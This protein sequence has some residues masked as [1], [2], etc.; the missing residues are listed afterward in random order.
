MILAGSAVYV[1][2]I[3]SH[4]SS[5]PDGESDLQFMIDGDIVGSANITPTGSSTYSYN[6]LVYSGQFPTGQHTLTVINGQDGGP[7]SMILLDYI[8]YTNGSDSDFTSSSSSSSSISTTT[9]THTSSGAATDTV[10]ESKN[11]SGG[12]SSAKSSTS[13]LNGST[14]TSSTPSNQTSMAIQASPST[15][16]HTPNVPGST[17]SQGSTTPSA[18]NTSTGTLRSNATSSS[19]SQTRTVVLVAVVLGTVL[20]LAIAAL[21]V[22]WRRRSARQTHTRTARPFQQLSSPFVEEDKEFCSGAQTPHA[23]LHGRWSAL[24]DFARLSARRDEM[25]D[26]SEQWIMHTPPALHEIQSKHPRVSVV[27]SPSSERYPHIASEGSISSE[28][29]V[30]SMEIPGIHN[31]VF[32]IS[33][34]QLAPPPPS[35][36]DRLRSHASMLQLREQLQSNADGSR[37]RNTRDDHTIA[38]RGS[39]ASNTSAITRYVPPVPRAS[40]VQPRADGGVGEYP[41][42]GGNA[43]D[44]KE[45]AIWSRNVPQLEDNRPPSYHSA[46]EKVSE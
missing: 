45:R 11:S 31:S 21:F 17:S 7:R 40:Y 46:G 41:T 27:P 36:T 33:M 30:A 35:K 4:S 13:S 43:R 19:S 34:Q 16:T 20:I 18:S 44:A 12:S 38:T 8:V 42:S 15:E 5:D 23:C 9:M 28:Q 14:A 26:L 2:C 24:L 3:I 1:Y 32:D 29:L 10:T 39:T 22:L 6:Y 25:R 37:E